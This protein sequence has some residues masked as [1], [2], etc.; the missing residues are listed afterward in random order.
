MIPGRPTACNNSRPRG[1]RSPQAVPPARIIADLDRLEQSFLDDKARLDKDTPIVVDGVIGAEFTYTVRPP[2]GTGVVTARTRHFINGPFYYALTVVSPPGHPLPDA[3]ARFLSSLTF[4]AA[5]EAHSARMAEERKPTA[6]PASPAKAAARPEAR[7]SRLPNRLEP[8]AA[9]PRT[10]VKPADSTPEDAF[11]T[12]IMAIAAQDAETLRAVTLP[13]DELAWLLRR[14]PTTGVALEQMKSR[15]DRRTIKRLKPGDTASMADG[16]S[17][18]L[19]ADDIRADCVV[20]WLEG[21]SYA[22][23]LLDVGG[24][25]KVVI[26]PFIAAHK[27]AE[28]KR[29]R[30]R[31]ASPR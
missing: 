26:R 20:I 1:I 3:A 18:I 27:A 25:W 22:T 2:Q 19:Q 16:T 8:K 11:K 13:D 28:A 6:R 7:A 14:G 23:T 17:R 4:E 31:P 29:T 24:H 5:I 9:G 21:A 30:P 10:R 15:L 12:F